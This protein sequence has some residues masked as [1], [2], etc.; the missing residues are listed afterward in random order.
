MHVSLLCF[1]ALKVASI[2]GLMPFPVACHCTVFLLL[3]FCFV[4]YLANNF[5]SATVWPTSDTVRTPYNCLNIQHNYPI[6][7]S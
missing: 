3:I 5:L 2:D 7:I 1:Y 6:L 4:M